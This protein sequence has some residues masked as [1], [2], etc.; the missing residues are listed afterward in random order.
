MPPFETDQP[1]ALS[2]D[3][4]QGMVHVIAGDRTDTVVAVNPSDRSRPVDIEAAQQT[5]VDMANGNLTIRVPKRRGITGYLGLGRSGSVDVTVELPEGSSLT[6]EAGFGDIRCDGTLGD[7]DVRTG[8]GSVR[9][10]RTG[11]VRVHSGAGRVS[12][13][14]ASGAADI[15]T[16][17]DITVGTV[18]G[19]TDVKNHSGTTRI[20]RVGGD[21]KVK[22]SNGDVTI[23]DAGRDVTVK[24]ANGDIRLGQIARGSATIETACGGLEI[25][26]MEGSAAWIDATTRFGQIRNTLSPADDPEQSAETVQVRARTSFGDVV[27]TRPRPGRGD[28]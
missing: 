5:R 28:G 8:A 18:A 2:I 12:V 26:I 9:L 16:T 25:G 27:I 24:T 15:V 20:G 3:L 17:G 1:I 4:T 23:E 11:A 22:S 7:V 10:D 21:V 13:E 6:A 14:G 19:D